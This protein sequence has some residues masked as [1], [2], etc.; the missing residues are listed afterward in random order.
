[1]FF[2]ALFFHFSNGSND[3]ILIC[4][5]NA[6]LSA[7]QQSFYEYNRFALMR[8]KMVDFK[9]TSALPSDAE[10]LVGIYAP[11][12]KNTAVSYEYEVPSV[13]EFRGR[14]SDTLRVYPYLKA[15]SPTGEIIGYA[16]AG[17]FGKRRAYDWTAEVSIYVRQDCRGKGI[18][19]AL[20]TELE[21]QLT[22][23]G[24][25]TLIA[26]V[27][28][29]PVE[30]EYLTLASFG[31]HRAMGYECAGYFHSVGYKF[32]RWYDMSYLEKQLGS[33]PDAPKNIPH[34]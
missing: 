11:Y 1:M 5:K 20:Y 7:R 22:A 32:G 19:R 10:E 4:E 3:A 13:D 25:Q 12:V 29:P 15:V 31:F 14:I 24:I 30:D 18:G 26:C 21:G 16:Y 28:C 6:A 17:R 34:A 27:A 2:I 8:W 9:I 33:H 23:L